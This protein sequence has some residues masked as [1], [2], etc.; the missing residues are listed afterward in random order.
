[1]LYSEDK[2]GTLKGEETKREYEAEQER[3]RKERELIVPTKTTTIKVSQSLLKRIK[4]KMRP[5]DT[6]N[7]FLVRELNIETKK[8][9]PKKK[10]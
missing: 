10:E 4:Q 8:S 3:K 1:M 6:Y 7:S 9:S 2:Y 5:N